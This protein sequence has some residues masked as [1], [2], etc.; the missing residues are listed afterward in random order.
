MHLANPSPKACEGGGGRGG[1]Y[2]RASCLLTRATSCEPDYSRTPPPT[3]GMN[4]PR[5]ARK[6]NS[7]VRLPR[8]PQHVLVNARQRE[9]ARRP[10]LQR[11]VL[12]LVLRRV[13]LP[14][15]GPHR[16]VPVPAAAA[17]LRR[18]VRRRLVRVP[19]P[20]GRDLQRQRWGPRRAGGDGRGSPG[21]PRQLERHPALS[22]RGHLPLRH[23]R[24]RW[25]CVVASTSGTTSFALSITSLLNARAE[26]LQRKER[27]RR[28][29]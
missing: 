3:Y 14:G 20:L 11:L 23:Q 1:R 19:R 15:E 4:R 2:T 27:G 17:H 28:G 8:P 5:R 21:R 9:L 22:R 26:T 24:R 25:R 10:L 16:E 6:R 29:Y 7:R 12:V 18:R 13:L